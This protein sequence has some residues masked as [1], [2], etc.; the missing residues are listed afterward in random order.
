MKQI[1]ATLIISVLLTACGGDEET[2]TTTKPD[3]GNG[4]TKKTVTKKNS[5]FKVNKDNVSLSEFERFTNIET[6]D[7][8]N[9][10][11]TDVLEQQARESYK[12]LD[13]ATKYYLA[14]ATKQFNYPMESLDQ[15]MATVRAAQVDPTVDYVVTNFNGE[16]I[17]FTY[18][19]SVG[20]VNWCGEGKLR[21]DS[22]NYFEFNYNW[23]NWS[24]GKHFAIYEEISKGGYSNFKA[25]FEYNSN[26]SEHRKIILSNSK[27]DHSTNERNIYS[28]WKAGDLISFSNYKE[29]N[30]VGF[31]NEYNY[32]LHSNEGEKKNVFSSSVSNA[33]SKFFFN[34]DG[35]ITWN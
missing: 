13:E 4:G 16:I 7:T 34:S 1:I 21:I 10:K 17:T 2:K 5:E 18:S 22:N 6:A 30:S 23:D 19:C 27:Y 28:F 11:T 9:D 25:I 32:D 20:G 31:G 3:S 35:G 12:A 29:T 33:V 8:D 14:A 15:L 24:K 26:G